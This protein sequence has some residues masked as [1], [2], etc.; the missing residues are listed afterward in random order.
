[1]AAGTGSVVTAE[2]NYIRNIQN[3][4]GRVPEFVTADESRST[5][6]VL[7]GREMT[8]SNARG[9]ATDVDQDGFALVHHVS[10]VVDFSLIEEDAQVDSCYHAEMTELL[11]SVTGAAVVI[12]LGNGKKRYG[13]AEAQS[14]L[15]NALPARFAHADNTDSSSAE[16]VDL[17]AASV[18]NLDLGNYQRWAMYNMWR[19]VSPPPQDIPLAVCDARTVGSEDEVTIKSVAS[20]RSGVV[21]HDTT[22]YRH[23]S[24]HR[25][26]YFS[27]MTRDE[28]LVFKAHDTDPDRSH[29]VPHTAFAGPP[30]P[31][32]TRTRASVEFRALALFG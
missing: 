10:S 20:E 25:W 11:K 15:M 21:V 3:P 7:P 6:Q 5:M 17:I 29:R 31:P 27:D 9:L 13:E 32:G 23:S 22:A 4:L 19:A 2:I 26:F 28:V 18:P 16:M 30:C 8:I 24:R 12:G 14:A 1:M